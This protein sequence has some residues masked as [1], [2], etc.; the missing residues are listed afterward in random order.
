[1]SAPHPFTDEE[2]RIGREQAEAFLLRI[3]SGEPIEV[4]SLAQALSIAR[5]GSCERQ[6]A[7]AA[8]VQQVLIERCR[9]A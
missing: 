4:D 8:R 1:M 6:R 2:Q 5:F 7:F 3:E 9:D